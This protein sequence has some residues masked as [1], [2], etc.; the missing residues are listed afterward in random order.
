MEE[1]ILFVPSVR[2]TEWVREFLPD[3]SPAELPVAGRRFIDYAFERAQKLDVMFTEVMDWH[4]SEQLAADFSDINRT[5]YPV[6]Y[7]KGEGAVPCG[8]NDIEGVSSPLT[9]RIEDGLIVAWGL[10][11]TSHTFSDVSFE[12]L[13][14]EECA[15]TPVGLYRRNNGRWMRIL[16]HGVVLKNADSWH[17]L[18]MTVLHNPDVFTLPGYSSEQ[19]VHLGRNV[20]ME[21]G[22]TVKSP[23]LLQDNVWCA[24]NVQI[25]GDVIIGKDSFVGEGARLFRT[26][27]CSNTY[28]GEGIE[29]VDKIIVGGRII[30]PKT[31]AWTDMGDDTGVAQTIGGEGLN[32]FARIWRFLAG[33]SR[34]RRR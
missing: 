30:D 12:P 28:V 23:V 22:T 1:N 33:T 19:G 5:G 6:F 2:E 24:R 18:N 16:P 13:P 26:V 29:L 10:C 25:D 34:G 3:R 11:L 27:V 17:R 31:G 32:I 15:N 21:L 8:L 7:V 20:V 14:E 4:F 9:Y